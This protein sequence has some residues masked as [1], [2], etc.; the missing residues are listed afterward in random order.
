MIKVKNVIGLRNTKDKG[1]EKSFSDVD[2]KHDNIY[3]VVDLY[4]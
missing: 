3:V 4:F 1:Y 2:L